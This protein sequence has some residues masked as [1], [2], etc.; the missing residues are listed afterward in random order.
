M[1][2]AVQRQIE[3]LMEQI[4]AMDSRLRFT[5][6]ISGLFLILGLA[7]MGLWANGRRK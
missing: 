3:P 6:V 5:D 7:G 2:A 4:E 1:D